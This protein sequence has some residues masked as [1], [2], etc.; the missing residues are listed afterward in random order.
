MRSNH[1]AKL[2]DIVKRRTNM[3]EL[4]MKAISHRERERKTMSIWDQVSS[5]KDVIPARYTTSINICRRIVR[6]WKNIAPFLFVQASEHP[7]RRSFP[8]TL[9]FSRTCALFTKSQ[10]IGL[11]HLH[12]SKRWAVFVGGGWFQWYTWSLG[13]RWTQK[14]LREDMCLFW[15]VKNDKIST[16]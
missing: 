7:N 9:W 5:N 4:N 14:H 6:L 2:D 10:W 3:S 13:V 16:V 8:S 12:H 15:V 11:L 1:I